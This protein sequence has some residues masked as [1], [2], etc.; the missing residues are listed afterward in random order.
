MDAS[1]IAAAAVASNASQTRDMM[2]LAMQ[3]MAAEQQ[4]AMANLLEQAAEQGKKT[5]SAPPGMG[6]VVDIST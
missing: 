3:K 2:A 5:A 4:Q 1:N 6:Q